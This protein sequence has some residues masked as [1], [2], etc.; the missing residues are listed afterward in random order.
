VNE[1]D[2]S[3]QDTPSADAPT[4]KV[5]QVLND[6]LGFTD[7][8][9]KYVIVLGEANFHS[10]RTIQYVAE[11]LLHRIG[12]A[13]S[14]L[15]PD[16]IAAHPEVRWAKMKGMRNVVAHKYGFIDYRIVWRALSDNLP[17]DAAAIRRILAQRE[18]Q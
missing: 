6:I 4:D 10:D 8:V 9:N 13:V 18:E 3:P 17:E 2:D 7:E 1:T 14:R 11:A 15:P 12:E 16:F 5:R